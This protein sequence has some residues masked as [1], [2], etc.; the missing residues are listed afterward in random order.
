M[1]YIVLILISLS[2][3]TLS[4]TVFSQEEATESV[5]A[6]RM[7]GNLVI[8]DNC[9]INCPCLF[10]FDPEHGHCRALGVMKV[11]EGSYGEVSLAGVSWGFLTEFTGARENQK[12][13]YAG[14]YI[15]DDASKEQEEALRSILA[16][17][18][19][20]GLGE[21]LG[22]KVVNVNLVVPDMATGE[23]KMTLGDM[24]DMVVMPVTG[25]DKESP[26]KVLNPVYPFPAKEIILG[27]ATGKF[28]D[29]G[30]DM[31]LEN[32]SG[33]ISEIELTGGGS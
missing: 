27:S 10:G 3:V 30:K 1:R 28:S 14:Y 6:W 11:A 24:G 25:N 7:K 5:P 9:G 12:W 20:S 32:N 8:T 26:Q 13:I 4:S 16:G 33:E 17:P 31:N 29:H 19:F 21:Q 18:P 2:L 22:V 23:Y 15:D